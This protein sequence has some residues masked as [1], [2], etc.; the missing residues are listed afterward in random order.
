MSLLKT[1][2]VYN[3]SAKNS[4]LHT[5]CENTFAGCIFLSDES[6]NG[7]HEGLCD[8]AFVWSLHDHNCMY[9]IPVDQRFWNN[10]CISYSKLWGDFELLFVSNRVGP[11]T[12]NFV[13][14]V[15]VTVLFSKWLRMKYFVTILFLLIINTNNLTLFG[16]ENQNCFNDLVGLE[17][18]LFHE[19]LLV[20]E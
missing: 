1:H 10:W 8:S 4:K 11:K 16:I 3:T 14:T 18:V 5:I 13:K 9:F 15:F 19:T 2:I 12:L 20:L 7:S 6:L 17:S